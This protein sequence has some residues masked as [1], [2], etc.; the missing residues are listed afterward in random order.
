MKSSI[1]DGLTQ[2][3]LKAL[4]DIGI[5]RAKQ[6]HMP[7][8]LPPELPPEPPPIVEQLAWDS[9]ANVRHSAR[10][11]MDEMGLTGVIDPATGLSAKDLLTSVIYQE[12]RF[13]PKAIG[14]P[15]FNNSRDYGLVQVNNG[16]N[17][18]DD[19]Y[20]I[21]PGA[22]FESTDEVLNDPAKNVRLLVEQYKAGNIHYWSSYV[23]R[24]Y[25]QWFDGSNLLV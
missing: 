17:A 4:R 25:R 20:W 15:N 21:G 9:P 5:L 7:P 23:S 11:I 8:S 6:Q 3:L 2:L 18:N 14:K 13:N 1:L 19:P 24:A 22:Y 10:V 12:S 16:H